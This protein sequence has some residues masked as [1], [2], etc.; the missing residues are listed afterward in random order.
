MISSKITIGAVILAAGIA[1]PALAQSPDHTGSQLPYYY[2]S[3]GGQMRGSWAPQDGGIHPA[4]RRH[5]LYGSA[6]GRYQRQ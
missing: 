4:T 1:S 3:T 2:D 6:P 5:T